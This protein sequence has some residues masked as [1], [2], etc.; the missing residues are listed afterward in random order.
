MHTRTP[1]VS[2]VIPVRNDAERL[3]R[4]LRTIR[5]NRYAPGIEII[6]ADNGSTDGSVEVALDAGAR[7]LMLPGL[8]VS[9]LRNRA[10]EAAT[11]RVLAFVDADHEIV[12][13]WVAS[14]VESLSTTPG[15]AAVGTL[16]RAPEQGNWVQ[17]TYDL[18]RRRPSTIADV[19]WLGSGNMALWRDAFESVGGFDTTL[20]TC[21]DVDLCRRLRR[22]GFRILQDPRLHNVHLGDPASLPDLFRGEL[23][24]GRDNLRVSLRPPFSWRDLPSIVLPIAELTF[25]ATAIAGAMMRS[26][27]GTMITAVSL[28]LIAAGVALRAG[29]MIRHAGSPTVLIC[30]QAFAVAAVYDAA[31]AA[32]LVRPGGH[33]GRRRGDACV[34][35]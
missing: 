22:S 6:V 11:G 8:P 12:D 30:A 18:L 3:Q 10:A 29:R 27:T 4:C 16:C 14:A 26:A 13:D 15:V 25:F 1:V 31:R 33:E 28:A 23:W 32:A 2:F 24:R 5:A 19:E 20:Q 21:E 35:P 17:R 9:E 34:K 7:V